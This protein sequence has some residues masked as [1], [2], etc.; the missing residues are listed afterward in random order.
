MGGGGHMNIAGCQLDNVTIEEAIA[1][2]KATISN[3]IE[4]GDL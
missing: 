1:T 2:L 4:A 3:M